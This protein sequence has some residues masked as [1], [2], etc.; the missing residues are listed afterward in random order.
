MKA[1][2]ARIATIALGGVLALS[3]CSGT[4]SAQTAATVDG[5]V[6][7][8]QDVTDATNQINEAFQQTLTPSQTLGLLI[9]A[10]L[11]NEAAAKAGRP[12]SESAVLSAQQ[13]QALD[14]DPAASTVEAVRANAANQALD[15]TALQDVLKQ[16]QKLDVV[17]NPR[18]GTFDSQQATVVASRPNWLVPSAPAA[19]AQ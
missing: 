19:P 17:V 10:P 2:K 1:A 4:T 12:V 18:Y 3:A 14:D 5:R 6:I 11:I 15:Q 8:V 13:L 16:V 7:T 9:V